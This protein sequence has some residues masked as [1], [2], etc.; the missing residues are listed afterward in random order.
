M[1]DNPQSAVSW[2]AHYQALVKSAQIEEAR[3][4][5]TAEGWSSKQ[6]APLAT[7]PRT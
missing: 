2:E 3:K 1:G 7:P 4:K 6:P 5:F